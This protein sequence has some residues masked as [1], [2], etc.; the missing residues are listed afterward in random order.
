MSSQILLDKTT[1]QV[2]L[3]EIFSQTCNISSTDFNVNDSIL[4]SGVNSL[5]LTQINYKI[6]TRYG[7]QLPFTSLTDETTFNTLTDKLYDLFNK[8]NCIPDQTQM[9]ARVKQNKQFTAD[10]IPKGFYKIDELFEYRKVKLQKE[11]LNKTASGN[12]YL[13]SFSSTRKNTISYQKKEY[14]NFSSYDYLGFSNNQEIHHAMQLATTQYGSS[15]SSSRVVSGEKKIHKMLETKLADIY[16]VDD[17]IVF[18]SGYLTNVTVISHLMG[19]KDLII[20]DSLSHQSIVMGS[21]FSRAQSF[22]F[23]HNNYSDL[24]NILKEHRF[25]YQKVLIIVEGLYSMHG[26]TPE[27]KQLIKLK[28][29]YKCLLMIDEAHSL[30]VLG[31][32]GF[33]IREFSSINSNDIDIWMGTLSKSLASCGGYI[34]GSKDLIEYLKYSVPGFIFSVGLPPPMAAAAL[35]SLALLSKN[36]KE[37][38]SLRKN[39]QYFLNKINE[40]GFNTGSAEG[41]AIIPIVLNHSI[42]TIKLANALFSKGINVQPIIYP[43]VKEDNARIRFFITATHTKREMDYTIKNL[44]TLRQEYPFI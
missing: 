4:S 6:Q 22:Q 27:I 23:I 33:G 15:A 36:N 29:K 43:A 2:E 37:I 19:R 13:K 14:I 26:D 9:L 3:K 10:N 38:I 12:P 21:T 17:S 11:L 42:N 18:V 31:E 40:E 24:E 20:Y 16:G 25:N 34:A 35:K 44:K 1:F 39:S 30:G 7:I 5:L 41:Y 32:N 8:K 28:K